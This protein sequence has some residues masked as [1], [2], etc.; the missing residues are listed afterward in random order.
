MTRSLSIVVYHSSKTQ[1]G[2]KKSTCLHSSLGCACSYVSLMWDTP[3]SGW[4]QCTWS[5]DWV[6]LSRRPKQE[7]QRTLWMSRIFWM[8][9]CSQSEDT[10]WKWMFHWSV[11]PSATTQTWP[12][13]PIGSPWITAAF[14]ISKWQKIK[15]KQSRPKHSVFTS[16]SLLRSRRVLVIEPHD[17]VS[18]RLAC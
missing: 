4:S 1:W 11:Y 7:V 13:S 8:I 14:P 16:V 17:W 15:L 5:L 10:N 9:P 3:I 18:S 6:L 2:I 12:I